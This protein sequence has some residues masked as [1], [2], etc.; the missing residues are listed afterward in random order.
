MRVLRLANS[1]LFAG[2][3]ASTDLR[4]ACARLGMRN[5]ASVAHLVA[6][7]HVY[8]SPNP[9]FRELMAQLWH[10]A[11]ATARLTDSVGSAV[12]G[13]PRSSLFLSGL[14][15]DVG[16]P[17]LLDVMTNRYRGRTGELKKS[18]NLL[19]NTLDEFSPYIGLRVVQHW[20]LA[21]EIRFT[22]FYANAPG[23][24]PRAYRRHAYLV[25]LAS[26]AAESAGFGIAGDQ[27][28]HAGRLESVG[29]AFAAEVSRDAAQRMAEEAADRVVAFMDAVA[30]S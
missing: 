1:A 5:I 23:A 3:E 2:R 14:V 12:G 8:K 11:V 17:V 15:H 26:L 20:R 19:L 18:W 28:R 7:E 24:A 27:H 6:H 10:H 4:L 25:A 9:V 22:T 21:P 16:K 13:L 30:A 29:E